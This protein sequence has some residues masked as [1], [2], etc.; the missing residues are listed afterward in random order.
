LSKVKKLAEELLAK[1]PTMFSADF[2]SNKK[3]L[4]QVAIIRNRALRNQIA[5][6]IAA[7]ASELAPEPESNPEAEA[8]ESQPSQ[9]EMSESTVSEQA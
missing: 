4:D 7:M 1:Y 9:A 2:E 6:A 8:A 5:G 3:A